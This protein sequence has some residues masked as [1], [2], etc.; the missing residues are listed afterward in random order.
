MNYI[1]RAII[2]QRGI[3]GL[4]S[5]SQR[6]RFDPTWLLFNISS[7]TKQDLFAIECQVNEFPVEH[8][9]RDGCSQTGNLYNPT[10]ISANNIGSLDVYPVGALSLKH[11][12]PN[13]M[14]SILTMWDINLSLFG[15][16]S[17]VHRSLV[18]YAL[19]KINCWFIRL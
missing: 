12:F 3:S 6:T 19:V 16:S 5:L 1:C 18:F 4:V 10:G 14:D 13:Y 9:L 17:V 7:V 11:E 8:S 15:A 2:Q